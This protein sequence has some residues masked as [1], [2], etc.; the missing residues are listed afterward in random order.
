MLNLSQNSARYLSINDAAK[1]S[2]Y[3]IKKLKKL[4]D[5]RVVRGGRLK[6]N[7]NS[8]FVDMESLYAH[9]EAQCLKPDR[10]KSKETEQKIVDFVRRMK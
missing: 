2:P 5:D 10:V 6:D 1:C 4:V 9:I 7:K 8:W 3:G